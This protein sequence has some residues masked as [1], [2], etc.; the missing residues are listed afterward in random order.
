MG[1]QNVGIPQRQLRCID[2]RN[3]AAVPSVHD[4]NM[5]AED[6]KPERDEK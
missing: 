3:G 6:D 1:F 4:G 2:S 5:C